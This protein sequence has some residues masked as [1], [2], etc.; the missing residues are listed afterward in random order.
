M[1]EA[2]TVER[3][4]HAL[5]VRRTG[6]DDGVFAGAEALPPERCRTAVVVGSS[7]LAA[8]SRLDPWVVADIADAARGGLRLVAPFLG[9]MGPNGSLP[10]ARLLADRLRVEV[11]AAEGTP[12]TLADGSLF[13]AEHG[14]GW[15]SYQPAGRRHR[16]GP[17]HPSPWWQQLLP[18]TPDKQVTEIPAGLWVRRPDASA[19]PDDPLFLAV[20]DRDRMYVVLG[21]PGEEPPAVESVAE[22]LRGLPDE[23]RDR[24]VL[25]DYGGA[26]VAEAVADVLGVPVRVSHGVPSTVGRPAF[27]DGS[28]TAGWRPFAVE[29]V[30]R[31]GDTPL[32]DRWVAPVP[33]LSMVEPAS[34][35]L[36]DGWRVDVLARGLLVRPETLVPDPAWAVGTRATADLVLAADGP[37]PEPVLAALTGLVRELPAD[38][39]D[40]L[41][42][43]PVTAHAATAAAGLGVA[44]D[45]SRP[46]RVGGH[47]V[48]GGESDESP[49]TP[50]EPPGGAV[51]VSADGR[52]LPA[53]PI[54]VVSDRGPVPPAV[55]QP[56][57]L[58]AVAA[59]AIAPVVTAAGEDEPAVTPVAVAQATPAGLPP[60]SVRSL[61]VGATAPPTVVPAS[62]P[63]A[64]VSTSDSQV[65][66][67]AE[68]APIIEV[69]ADARSTAEQRQ[70]VRGRLR[71]RY[72]VAT[73]AVT[74]LLSERP[75]LRAGPS[76]Q[77][78]LLAELAVVWMFAEEP[79]ASYDIDF[80]VCLAGGLRRLP[81]V[82]TVVARG[83]PADT[84][85]RPDA[86]VRLA[87]PVVAAPA[88]RT[89]LLGPAEALI[90]TTT[91]RKLDGLVAH[92][93]ADGADG[94][95]DVV[96]SAHT[97][98]R[99]LAVE[100]GAVRR[101]LL[102]EDGTPSDAALTR[103][104]AAAAT[105]TAAPDESP[106][107][108]RWFGSLPA[109]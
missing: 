95:A 92:R 79:G 25:A 105:R 40:H 70:A 60:M 10:P 81:T 55:V 49:D 24:A 93:P 9:A 85:V 72:D 47:P 62:R 68:P 104:R 35:R 86:I 21:A 69:P 33:T 61:S 18:A 16:M 14:A 44:A 78:T 39:R 54:L 99:V 13:V 66:A 59:A 108:S 57:S 22:V 46:L 31:P 77:A 20:P 94:G 67:I 90:W 7:A 48:P 23:Q 37:V 51:V 88:A 109:A 73:S 65:G 6:A 3:A 19:R 56:P 28:G 29:S 97:R 58:P 2:I 45:P 63:A 103:L 4:R 11:V 98:L 101:I 34:Y 36:A 76:D 102:A 74:R 42:V 80:H 41:R 75:G 64:E 89:G 43:V 5:V 1:G 27:V 38:A 26:G 30:Y 50:V 91:A 15:V 87:A 82:R 106:Y 107:D 100:T 53:E 32:L 52:V 12:V 71:S 96:L 83:I 17:R 84:D 8:V